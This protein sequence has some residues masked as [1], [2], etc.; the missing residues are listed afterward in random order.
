M[1][2]IVGASG[3]EVDK[4]KVRAICDWPT[5]KIVSNVWSSWLGYWRFIQNFNSIVAL[6]TECLK[7][8]NFSGVR[9]NKVLP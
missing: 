7:K 6:I 2:F 5:P 9:K 4:E 8:R 1:G 3:V